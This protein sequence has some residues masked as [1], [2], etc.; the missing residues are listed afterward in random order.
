ME[1][2]I[3]KHTKRI[4]KAVKNTKQSF[5]EKLKEVAVEVLIIVFAVT[6]SIGLHGWYEHREQQKEVKEFLA[7]LKDDLNKDIEN[8]TGETAKLNSAIEG[9]NSLQNITDHVI[10]SFNQAKTTIQINTNQIIRTS[11]QGDYEGFKS[12]GKISLIENKKLKKLILEYN[13]EATVTL[14]ELEKSYNQL[15]VKTTDYAIDNIS[16]SDKEILLSSRFKVL[17]RLN[18]QFADNIQKSY[19]GATALAKQ[20]IKEIDKDLGE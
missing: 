3:A 6:L 15:M 10:D 4:Y 8:L 16:K 7:D 17:L 18:L 12:S 13:Q 14:L 20:I 2:E 19:K 9:F 11:Y 1:D 5:A